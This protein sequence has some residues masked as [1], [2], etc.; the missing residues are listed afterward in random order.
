VH[1]PAT[2]VKDLLSSDIPSDAT[3]DTRFLTHAR[4]RPEGYGAVASACRS[5]GDTST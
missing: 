2:A 5:G 4:G 1:G 3:K